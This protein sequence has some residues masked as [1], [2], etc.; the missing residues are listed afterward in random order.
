MIA[1]PMEYTIND[2]HQDVGNKTVLGEGDCR[3]RDS[4][5]FL[6]LEY[7]DHGFPFPQSG[8]V[9]FSR[10]PCAMNPLFF[11]GSAQFP[12]LPGNPRSI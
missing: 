3:M 1:I 6:V 7:L 2:A 9:Q 10:F 12:F 4:L 11:K 8:Q 5:W